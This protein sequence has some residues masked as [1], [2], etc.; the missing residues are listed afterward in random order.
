MIA[1]LIATTVYGAADKTLKNLKSAY[2]GETEAVSKYTQYAKATTKEHMPFEAGLFAA[3]S[4]SES[5]HARNHLRVLNAHGIFVAPTKYAGKVGSTRENIIDS[6]IDENEEYKVMYPG[7]IATAN[8]EGFKDA[9]STFTYAQRAEKGHAWFFTTAE[10]REKDDDKT[11]K[12]QMF[13]CM[14]CGQTFATKA[15]ASCP[16]CGKPHPKPIALE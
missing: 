10:M 8:A 2:A 16:V 15:P 13:V 14:G 12:V 5:V 9:V 11:A 3:I 4:V 1:V 7:Y 6:R